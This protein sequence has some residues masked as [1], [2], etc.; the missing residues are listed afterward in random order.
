[1]AG[2]AVG[3]HL[4][5]E[6]ADLRTEDDLARGE[7]AGQRRFQ[8]RLQLSVLALKIKEGNAGRGGCRHEPTPFG[9]DLNPLRIRAVR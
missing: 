1:M 9:L 4:F 5:F 2:P 7:D 6:G 8:L 3:G